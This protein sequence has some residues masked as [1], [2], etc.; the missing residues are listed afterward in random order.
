LVIFKVLITRPIIK[1]II[2]VNIR[3]EHS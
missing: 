2:R 3:V 1:T